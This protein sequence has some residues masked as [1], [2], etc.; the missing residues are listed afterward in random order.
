MKEVD[1][2][3]E[4]DNLESTV[5]KLTNPHKEMGTNEKTKGTMDKQFGNS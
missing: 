4:I 3:K 2:Q 5:K 1:T